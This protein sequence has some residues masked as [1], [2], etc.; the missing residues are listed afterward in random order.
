MMSTISPMVPSISSTLSDLANS[1]QISPS[2]YSGYIR[3][4]SGYDDAISNSIMALIES[5]ASIFRDRLDSLAKPSLDDTTKDPSGGGV[6]TEVS[7]TIVGS[8]TI[9][10]GI[11][12]II[13]ASLFF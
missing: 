4:V 12:D 13:A 6:S 11:V 1:T 2:L 7:N 3:N 9:P 8:D 5:E 10:I